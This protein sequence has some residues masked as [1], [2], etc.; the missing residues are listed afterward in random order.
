MRGISRG[1]ARLDV[2]PDIVLS[3]PYTRARETAEILAAELDIKSSLI[4]FSDD[5]VPM[6]QPSSLLKEIAERFLVDNLAV[7]GHEPHLS[8]LISY[9]LTGKTEMSTD[10]KKGGVCLISLLIET[11]SWQASLEWLMTPRQL[12]AIGKS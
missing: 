9:L 12:L 7:V 10:L 1:L 4:K 11:Q 5:L 6:A 2:M 3:S 8:S